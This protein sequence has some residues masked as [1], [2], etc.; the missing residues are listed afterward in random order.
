MT[1]AGP[2]SEDFPVTDDMVDRASEDSFP[3]SDP[4]AYSIRRLPAPGRV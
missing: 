2:G 3:A 1:P 4:P